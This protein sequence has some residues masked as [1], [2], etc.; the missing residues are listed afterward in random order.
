VDGAWHTWINQRQDARRLAGEPHESSLYEFKRAVEE[1]RRLPIW[2]RRART[3]TLPTTHRQ[4]SH[5]PVEPLPSNTLICALGQDVSTCPI[6]QSLYASVR[7]SSLRQWS[8]VTIEDGDELAARTCV[9]HILTTKLAH[10][11]AYMNDGYVTDASERLYWD[12]VMDNL[13]G[14][15]GLGLEP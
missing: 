2:M 6:L 13:A 15:S 12:R 14:S 9:W 5:S 1:L 8:L 11:N 7:E 4:W 10:P 3:G